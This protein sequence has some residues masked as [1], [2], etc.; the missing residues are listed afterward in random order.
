MKLVHALLGAM[1]G[2]ETNFRNAEVQLSSFMSVC[3]KGGT[4]KAVF[5]TVDVM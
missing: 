4:L 1:K 5:I 3:V 2:I